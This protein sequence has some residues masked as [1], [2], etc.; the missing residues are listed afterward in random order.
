M[1]ARLIIARKTAAYGRA[2]RS[3]YQGALCSMVALL[4]DAYPEKEK[5]A[6]MAEKLKADL[7]NPDY[8]LFAPMYLNLL[9]S[10]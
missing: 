9:S 4:T 3:V 5:R 7:N 1:S 10:C 6:E 8:H 2:T